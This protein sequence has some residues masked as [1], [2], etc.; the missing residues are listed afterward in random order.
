MNLALPLLTKHMSFGGCDCTRYVQASQ[1]RPHDLIDN[2]NERPSDVQP[3]DIF[4]HWSNLDL[5]L[6][7][8]TLTLTYLARADIKPPARQYNLTKFDQDKP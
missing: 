7:A 4:S 3:Q 1:D 2:D 5:Y 8:I 6:Q